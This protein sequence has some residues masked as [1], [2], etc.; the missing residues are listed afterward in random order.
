MNPD[1]VMEIGRE[2]VIACLMLAGPPLLAA[3]LVGLV[4]SIFQ[5]ATQVNEATLAFVP[6]LVAAFL[7]LIVAGPW[8]LQYIVEF[9]REIFQMIPQ[10]VG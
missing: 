9:I 7:M 5:A 1:I 6:K 8:M 4:I 3:L 10:F 2:A